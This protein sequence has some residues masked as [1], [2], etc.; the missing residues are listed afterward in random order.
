MKAWYSKRRRS[1]HSRRS[2]SDGSYRGPRRLKR[3]RCC[4]GAIVEIGSIWRKPSRRMV[5]RTP[6]ALPS[7][8][9][10]CT[11][12]RPACARLTVI[13]V[14]DFVLS[15]L[16]D[17]RRRVLEVGCGS[18][19][20]AR[21]LADAG[22]DVTAIDPEAPEGPLFRRVTLEAFDDP[23]PFDAVVASRSLH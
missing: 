16:G 18:G 9:C 7:R 4:G 12:M 5:S 17:G 10:A 15:Q 8:S 23:R 20:L 1:C 13:D 6:S 14:I 2:S 19:E 21:A 22:H 3:T 11:A